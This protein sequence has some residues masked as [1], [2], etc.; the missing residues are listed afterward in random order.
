MGILPGP[1][2]PLLLG[3]TQAATAA[4]VEVVNLPM[5]TFHQFCSVGVTLGLYLLRLG[6]SEVLRGTFEAS[7]LLLSTRHMTGVD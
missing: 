6:S 1:G 5:E 3:L 2:G 4:P 7:M